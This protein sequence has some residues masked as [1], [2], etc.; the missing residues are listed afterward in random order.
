MF[1][2]SNHRTPKWLK[3]AEKHLGFLAIPN[4]AILIITLQAFGTLVVNHNPAWHWRLALAPARVMELGEYWR[5]LTFL[6]LPLSTSLFWAIFV[7][8]FIYFILNILEEQWGSFQTTFYVLISVLLMLALSFSL[9]V[10]ILDIGHFESTLFLAAAT[11]F[12][13]FEILLFFFLPV[14][15]KWLAWFTGAY[16]IWQLIVGSWPERA[17]LAG[18]YANYLLFF[19]PTLL[20]QIKRIYRNV[21]YKRKLK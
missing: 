16:V 13:D 12:P 9:K 20:Y 3:K 8:W 7:L 5:L 1:G 10:P 4:I 15:L 6:A 11:L 2:T 18:I 17:M 19:G 14:K 21:N